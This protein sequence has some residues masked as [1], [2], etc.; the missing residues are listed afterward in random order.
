M[1]PHIHPRGRLALVF[2]ATALEITRINHSYVFHG[3][4]GRERERFL[5]GHDI[6]LVFIL[7]LPLQQGTR[8]R[9]ARLIFAPRGVRVSSKI[10]TMQYRWKDLWN[11]LKRVR[12]GW[13]G[14]RGVKEVEFLSFFFSFLFLE[15]GGKNLRRFRSSKGEEICI[16]FGKVF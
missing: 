15:K 13:V 12:D 5:P 16:S 9:E 4:G 7:R 8:K 1:R 6:A 3:E 11:V 14:N 10:G 2:L